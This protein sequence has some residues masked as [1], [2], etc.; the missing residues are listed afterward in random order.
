MKKYKE[1]KTGRIWYA[2]C[3]DHINYFDKN[4]N[5]VEIKEE[6]KKVETPKEN[7]TEK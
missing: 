4:P 1:K 3:K 6:K 5:F 7:T 2:I